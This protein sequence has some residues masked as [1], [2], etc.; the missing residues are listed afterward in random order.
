MENSKQ[1]TRRAVSYAEAARRSQ[2]PTVAT[3]SSVKPERAPA[4]KPGQADADA[5]ADTTKTQNLQPETFPTL[6]S[7]PTTLKGTST[8][9]PARESVTKSLESPS[10][11][12][13][14]PSSDNLKP[15]PEPVPS[16]TP[17]SLSKSVK[18]DLA[19]QNPTSSKL[20]ETRPKVSYAEA[21]R[22]KQIKAS[23]LTRPG[24]HSSNPMI[25]GS[26]SGTATPAAAGAD[27][28]AS[29]TSNQSS[30]P[31]PKGVKDDGP[32]EMNEQP[33]PQ[34]PVAVPDNNTQTEPKGKKKKKKSK[35]KNSAT[36][37]PVDVEPTTAPQALP[38]PVPAPVSGSR[39]GVRSKKSSSSKNSKGV[40]TVEKEKN[41]AVTIGEALQQNT[42][43]TA[44]DPAEVDAFVDSKIKEVVVK[45][46][47]RKWHFE[48][49]AKRTQAVIAAHDRG[50][51][52]VS[53]WETQYEWDVRIIWCPED[54]TKSVSWHVH[55]D[56]LSRES[57]WFKA[58]LPPKDTYGG[59]VH[60]DCSKHQ[61]ELLYH[62][63]KWMYDKKYDGAELDLSN[64]IHP[65]DG[66]PIRKNVFMY[67]CGMSVDCRSLMTYAA[68]RID[69]I[70]N[71]ILSGKLL[72]RDFCATHDIFRFTRPLT[73]A[74]FM[75]YEQPQQPGQYHLRLAM[76]RLLDV[77]MM[78]LVMN[79]SFRRTIDRDWVPAI[80]QNAINDNIHFRNVGLLFDLEYEGEGLEWI[81]EIVPPDNQ[82]ST[83]RR[84]SGSS[85]ETETPRQ[86]ANREA[87]HRQGAGAAGPGGVDIRGSPQV[88]DTHGH[89]QVSG[90]ASG[91]ASE[92]VSGQT[93]EMAGE[94]VRGQVTG[95]ASKRV[96]GQTSGQSTGQVAGKVVEHTSGQVTGKVVE[97][98]SGQVTEKATKQ[99]SGQASGQTSEKVSGKVSA[100]V[101]GQASKQTK[102]TGQVSGQVTGKS[103]VQVTGQTSGQT[104]GKTS[105]QTSGQGTGQTSGQSTGHSTGQ[106]S[107]QVSIYGKLKRPDKPYSFGRLGSDNF[108]GARGGSTSRIDRRTMDG[109]QDS[110]FYVRSNP[111]TFTPPRNPLT[112]N[113]YP[114]HRAQNA[115]QFQQIQEPFRSQQAHQAYQAQLAQHARQIFLDQQARQ[116]PGEMTTMQATKRRKLSHHRAT[117]SGVYSP[118]PSTTGLASPGPG[119]ASPQSTVLWKTP[120]PI[121]TNPPLPPGTFLTPPRPYH[122]PAPVHP[123]TFS[124]L[125]PNPGATM[126]PSPGGRLIS[127]GV[128]FPPGP[129]FPGPGGPMPPPAVH[130]TAYLA[131]PPP[132]M[133]QGRHLS[134]TVI[135][136]PQGIPTT[137][138][139]PPGSSVGTAQHGYAPYNPLLFRPA[140][141]TR[142]V[143]VRFA[144]PVAV[145]V[146]E[147]ASPGPGGSGSG[148]RGG[149]GGRG[150]PAGWRR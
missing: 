19:A 77:L 33:S 110:T 147:S 5:S 104:S 146:G 116:F 49:R 71:K 124:P 44:V 21:L 68:T 88:S 38:T 9:K 148:G 81:D 18:Q 89:G 132:P 128:A 56:I 27:P 73:L 41:T 58:R 101:S 133:P 4:P 60:L 106:N 75:M 45:E 126:L 62:V 123:V 83:A 24:P 99:S 150:G 109:S 8:S 130:R 105:G 114:A 149:R 29:A 23:S 11:T 17:K 40:A 140:G 107:G 72:T 30:G 57:E 125:G 1:P 111:S 92:K 127:A 63:L 87:S 53:L 42:P 35:N 2:G 103:T 108:G 76:T 143:A 25:T 134:A 67:I 69:D 131:P 31:P 142:S 54:P 93:G 28:A 97:Q 37:P 61:P 100:K 64:G 14:A 70:S 80:I 13:P 119:F 52:Q 120:S 7:P 113:F 94:Q 115:H 98:S 145:V 85:T 15:I 79:D 12:P 139:A 84:L 20:K 86:R 66:E 137:G 65:L 39:D 112:L 135:H 96:S 36:N 3:S 74:L 118:G 136:R 50:E 32:G 16:P 48:E 43:L 121:A 82:G 59:S 78:Q 10:R 102:T 144:D 46:E 22:G 90:Q 47:I 117:Y 122:F 141:E 6:H 91:Q 51:H 55:H 129:V 138:F 26:G 95:Q 34:P